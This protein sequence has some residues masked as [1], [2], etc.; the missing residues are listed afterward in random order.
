VHC[1]FFNI[2]VVV[3]VVVIVL[4]V[5]AIADCRSLSKNSNSESLCRLCCKVDVAVLTAEGLT[6]ISKLMSSHIVIYLTEI[7]VSKKRS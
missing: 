1:S 7:S 6:C 5:L 2:V 3:V 4:V